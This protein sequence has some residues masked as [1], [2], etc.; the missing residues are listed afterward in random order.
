MTYADHETIVV[1]AFKADG[2]CY[3]WWTGRLIADSERGLVITTR[4][5]DLV[6]QPDGDWVNQRYVRAFYWFDRCFNLNELAD[7]H[8]RPDMIYAHITSL[9]QRVG[10]E[11]HY[12][13]YELD[14]IRGLEQAGPPYIIDEDEFEA[15]IKTYGYPP[16]L[17]QQC[18]QAAET[19]VEFV[20]AWPVGGNTGRLLRR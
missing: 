13:D 10:D 6:R 14:V 20:R 17:V 18:R 8:R 3:R 5:G 9:P 11:L 1:K 12:I 7:A 4:P 2:R 19:A 16:H 15:A